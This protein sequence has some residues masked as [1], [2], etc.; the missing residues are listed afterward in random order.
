LK[1]NARLMLA[2]QLLNEIGIIQQLVT[3]ELNRLLPEGMHLSHFSVLNHLV[4]LGDGHTPNRIASAFQVTRATMT[5]TLTRLSARGMIDVRAN[6]EDGRSKLVYLTPEGVAFHQRAY[7]ALTPFVEGMDQNL[8][9]ENLTSVLP[10]L[11]ELR[12]Y[13]DNNR[14][15]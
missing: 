15:T 1:K 7:I 14:S 6:P 4:R 2:S 9:L 13:L 10:Q 8:D 3:T 11:Q 12:E 5:N